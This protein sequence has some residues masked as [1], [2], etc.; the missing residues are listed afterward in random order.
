MF[1]RNSRGSRYRKLMVIVSVV[2]LTL[3]SG[4]GGSAGVVERHC[5]SSGA[6][7]WVAMDVMRAILLV[8]NR[9]VPELSRAYSLYFFRLQQVAESIGPVVC[10]LAHQ[11]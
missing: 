10:F 3:V 6:V 4:V 2:G 5:H 11:G 8:G 7:A 1:G 9:F